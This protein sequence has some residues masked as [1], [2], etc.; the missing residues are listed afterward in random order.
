MGWVTVGGG[1]LKFHASCRHT[2]PE[3]DAFLLLLKNEKLTIEDI[4]RVSVG[5]HQ[6]ALDVLNDSVA[7]D[8]ISEAKFS[9]GCVLGFLA[10]YGTAGVEAFTLGTIR[11]PQVC[12]FLKRVS[13]VFDPE[14]DAA[15]PQKW[16]GKVSVMTWDQRGIEQRLEFPKGD[17][18]NPLS[19]D[20]RMATFR[21]LA[22][23]GSLR[24]PDAVI[25]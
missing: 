18:Q 5:V 22:S 8:T 3:A 15:Y 16:I 14:V 20:E 11:N 2:H 6:G 13:M 19:P 23:F 24:E 21:R 7:P 17:P 9:M 25:Y 4:D 1:W 12:D 10:H